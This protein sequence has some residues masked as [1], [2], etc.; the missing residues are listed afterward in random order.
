MVTKK[1]H[2]LIMHS[3]V[4]TLIDWIKNHPH[5]APAEKELKDRCSNI[6]FSG[7]P[8]NINSV[9]LE[10]ADALMSA[11]YTD[12]KEI[13]SAELDLLTIIASSL[14]IESKPPMGDPTE[15]LILYPLFLTLSWESNCNW[16]YFPKLCHYIL[17]VYLPVYEPEQIVDIVTSNFTPLEIG[18]HV[19]DKKWFENEFDE[20]VPDGGIYYKECLLLFEYISDIYG[21]IPSRYDFLEKLHHLYQKTYSFDTKFNAIV[22]RYAKFFQIDTRYMI[23]EII[24]ILQNNDLNDG[25]YNFLTSWSRK[26]CKKA[27]P[28]IVRCFVRDIAGVMRQMKESNNDIDSEFDALGKTASDMIGSLWG[29]DD[30]EYNDIRDKEEELTDEDAP[31]T[32]IASVTEAVHKDSPKMNNAERNIYKAYR[33]Y[34]DAEEKVD[35]QITKALNGMKRVLTG[36]VRSEIIEGKKFSAIGLLKQLL[37]TAALFSFGKIKGVIALVVAYALKK[38]TTVSE[39]R[40]ILMELDT[41]IEMIT[42]KIEDARGDG[43][44]KAKYSMMRTKK[45]LENAK[46]R[47]EYGLEADS[48]S[49][50]KAK[51]TLDTARNMK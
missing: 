26:Y 19:F 7:D 11:L 43:N 18:E 16:V 2:D 45:E 35:S 36:D 13:S 8:S 49:L 4:P 41:E 12:R 9:T 51:S 39:R 38:K 15:N 17:D 10:D 37:G 42:E 6:R 23:S 24:D 32:F 44:R 14:F 33:S 5:L 25:T 28:D 40:K 20:R 1:D 21:N 27:S 47:I 30:F 48:R 34:K 50:S 46:K 3:D 31:I 29:N 22:E